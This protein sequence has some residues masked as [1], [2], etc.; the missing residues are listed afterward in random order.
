MTKA[1]SFG[2]TAE[3]YKNNEAID[4]QLTAEYVAN[5]E[6]SF[7]GSVARKNR[8]ASLSE[9]YPFF[10]W[11]VPN[12]SLNP[13]KS[14]SFEAGTSLVYDVDTVVN[15]SLFYNSIE[16]MI[17][18]EDS[19]SKNVA[20]ATMKGSE[21]K[22]SNYSLADHELELSYAYIDAKDGD[23]NKISN[24]PSS[25]LYLQDS[26]TLGSK[27]KFLLSYLYVNERESVYS[28]TNYT[29][30]A[31]SLVDTQ[32]SYEQNKNLLFKFG[33][34]NLFDTNWEY[35]YGQ[36]ALGRSAFVNLSY[37]Y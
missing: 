24:I 31:Y 30:D 18:Y 28:D 8:F 10:P 9:L 12:Q 1:H 5:K 16:D 23:N 27:T 26:V 7:Y 34:K 11:D 15:L 14:N 17:V 4:L 19:S 6:L 35:S 36:P 3:D 33:I 22:I 2:T 29:L 20:K 25:K 37:T 32:L 13:E 21:V